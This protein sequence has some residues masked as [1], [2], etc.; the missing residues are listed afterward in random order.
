M[1]LVKH[2]DRALG[3]LAFLALP[4]LMAVTVYAQPAILSVGGEFIDGATIQI[5]GNAFGTAPQVISWDD[6]EGGADGATL[7]API[8]GPTWT[9]QHPSSNTPYPHYS[10]MQAYSGGQSAKVAWKEPGW[11]GYSINAFGWASEGPFN[12]MYL[13]Y[14]RYHDPSQNEPP[15]DM[16]HKQLYTFGPANSG[17]GYEQQQFMPFMV[18]DGAT[19]FA[20]MLQATPADIWYWGGDP[21][22][23]N[24]NYMWR[25]WEVWL[26]YE[27]TASRNDGRFKIW[28]DLDL[29]R[30][31]SGENLCDVE[32]GQYVEDLRIGH[33]FQGFNALSYVRSFFDD[34]YVAT[35]P[36][37]VE[38]GDA[39]TYEACTRREIQVAEN[40]STSF[41]ELPLRTVTFRSG[42]QVYLYVIDANGNPSSAYPIEL[43]EFGD[44]DPGP[45][46]EPGQPTRS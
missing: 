34:V 33:M 9:F 24:S 35:T 40:W 20:T 13:S 26:D 2:R 25:R 17:S 45:P 7:G 12:T 42:E 16:N 19:S 3:A 36:A 31:A 27:D 1:T 21:R 23:T 14:M 44:P 29:K 8:I 39:A 15:P 30:D 38:L 10:P 11:S 22:Y 37:R 41:I 32:G 18:P 5:S 6:F 4:L 46:G 43:G 28:Y